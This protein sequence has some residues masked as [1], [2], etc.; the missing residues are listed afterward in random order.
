MKIN[1]NITIQ[2][3]GHTDSVGTYQYNIELSEKR[4]KSVVEYL[5]NKGIE[6]KRMTYKG[7]GYTKPIAENQ[8]QEGKKINRSTEILILKK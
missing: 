1:E 7:Y 8:T 3:N 2:V 4:A 6:K 5:E